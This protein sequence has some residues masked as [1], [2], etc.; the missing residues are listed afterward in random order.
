MHSL[1]TYSDGALTA[2]GY[3][4]PNGAARAG[5]WALVDQATGNV[6]DLVPPGEFRVDS[7]RSTCLRTYPA[8]RRIW[9]RLRV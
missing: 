4:L 8:F 5:S 2:K 9:G 6:Q 3:R 1:W 7:G